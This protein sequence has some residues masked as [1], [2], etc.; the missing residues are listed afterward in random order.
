MIRILND[1]AWVFSIASSLLSIFFIYKMVKMDKRFSRLKKRYNNLLSDATGNQ[2]L[3]SILTKQTESVEEL[4]KISSK[5]YR[6]QEKILQDKVNNIR[7]I[8]FVRYDAFF[9]SNNSLSY[10]VVFLNEENTGVMLTNLFGRD[11]SS[12]YAR[13]IINGES[14]TEL[15]KEEHEA[16]KRAIES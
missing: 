7:K 8:G 12:S 5:I 14:E 15:S 11:K 1:Y 2:D 3:E 6:R 4:F 16:L 13:E 10:T 9:D